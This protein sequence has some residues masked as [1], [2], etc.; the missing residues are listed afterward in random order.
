MQKEEIIKALREDLPL[1]KTKYG[2]RSIGLFGS[3]AT[4]TNGADSDLDFLVELSAP[5]AK[6]YFGLWAY[7]ESRFHRKI[8]LVRKGDHLRVPFLHHIQS[9]I[10]YA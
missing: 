4:G 6:N 10:V 3:Y 9:E 1:L 5:L 2:V 7:L 8:D